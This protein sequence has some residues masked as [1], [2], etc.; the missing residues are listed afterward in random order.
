MP[1]FIER[2]VLPVLATVVM[3]VCAYN[4]WRWG[5]QPRVSLGLAA[6]LLAYFFAIH[7]LPAD[8]P[9]QRVSHGLGPLNPELFISSGTL[10]RGLNSAQAR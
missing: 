9:N 10:R 7:E 4:P 5:W 3:G 1:L 6:I 8:H 2:F